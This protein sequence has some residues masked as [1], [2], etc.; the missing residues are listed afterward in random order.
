MGPP[1]RKTAKSQRE[2][3]WF[4]SVNRLTGKLYGK[5]EEQKRVCLARVF[6]V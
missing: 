4:G 5:E 1:R 2:P 3:D 6:R